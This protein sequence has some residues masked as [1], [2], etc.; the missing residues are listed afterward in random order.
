MLRVYG[1]CDL[2]DSEAPISFPTCRGPTDVVHLPTVQRAIP[3]SFAHCRPAKQWLRALLP[4]GAYLGLA[5]S[6]SL[7]QTKT[8]GLLQQL[9]EKKAIDVPV[10]SLLLINGKEGILSIGGTSAASVR[11]AEKETDEMLSTGEHDETKRDT[12]QAKAEDDLKDW[13]WM[14][15]QGADGWWQILMRGIWVDGIKVM[16]NQPIILDVSEFVEKKIGTFSHAAGQYAVHRRSTHSSPIIL[17]L[18]IRQQT[19]FSALR[20]IPRLSLFQPTKNTLRVRT[21]ECPS[22]KG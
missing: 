8:L 13:K 12:S 21:V 10:W 17:L 22:P 2:V 1:L 3:V 11:Q 7:S 9:L 15:V 19:A 20:P 5:P 6:A 14:K 4:S 16:D 18:N